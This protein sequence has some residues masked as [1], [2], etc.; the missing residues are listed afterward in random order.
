MIYCKESYLLCNSKHAH[1][2]YNTDEKAVALKS[3]IIIAYKKAVFNSPLKALGI[4]SNHREQ[5]AAAY[6]ILALLYYL[7]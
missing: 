6:Q 4:K 2:N 5:K 7:I 1:K 3:E